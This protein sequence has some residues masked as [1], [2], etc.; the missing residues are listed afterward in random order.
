MASLY[1]KYKLAQYICFVISVICCLIPAIITAIRIIPTMKTDDKKIAI[2]GVGII[3]VA[4]VALIVCRSVIRKYIAMIPY[5]LTVMISVGAMLL[6]MTAIE[7]IISDAKAILFV[8]LIGSAAGFGFELASM[9]FKNIAL[10][11]KDEY[12]RRKAE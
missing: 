3:M 2:G 5:T 9:Y 11:I 1:K 8:S 4:V 10:E 12:S 7:K 6:V